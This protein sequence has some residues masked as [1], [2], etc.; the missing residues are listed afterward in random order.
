M[1]DCGTLKLG[2]RTTAFKRTLDTC[3][4]K[5]HAAAFRMHATHYLLETLSANVLHVAG[6]NFLHIDC[7]IRIFLVQRTF[8]ATVA[9]AL[10]APQDRFVM[11]TLREGSP[12]WSATGPP[13]GSPKLPGRGGR[14]WGE[15]VCK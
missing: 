11:Y 5:L 2:V 12:F 14:P 6:C 8:L 4:W 10:V 3:R 13:R 1:L 9:A 15:G 7:C